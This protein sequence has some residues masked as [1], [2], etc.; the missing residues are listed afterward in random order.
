MIASTAKGTDLHISLRPN[1]S[2]SWSANKW[3]IFGFGVFYSL[4]GWRFYALGAWP[5][6]PIIALE[7]ALIF[8]L[9]KRVFSNLQA[10][11]ELLFQGDQLIFN[12]QAPGARDHWRGAI[13]ETRLLVSHR[14]H[15]WDPPRLTLY[16]HGREL[17]L[18]R[19]LP[20]DDCEALIDVLRTRGL[21]CRESGDGELFLA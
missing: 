9:L 15:P 14:P 18:G 12:T 10:R 7:L 19:F 13:T 17:P 11:Q 6:L 2:A 5:L 3:I 16:N 4:V 20:K 1:Q 21:I 8:A